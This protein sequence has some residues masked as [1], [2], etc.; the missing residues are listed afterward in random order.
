MLTTAKNTSDRALFQ[1]GVFEDRKGKTALTP[2]ATLSADWSP[3]NDSHL[4]V[5]ECVQHVARML[6]ATDGGTE[7]AARLVADM[8]PVSADARKLA[9]RLFEIATKKNWSAEALVYNELA[10]VWPK[11]ED[12]ATE[13]VSRASSLAVGSPQAD[14]FG[15]EA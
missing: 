6:V 2:R 14:L 13:I 5:W 11:L 8:G 7:A 15:M 3:A 4:T 1:S 9:Y 10:E 12:L